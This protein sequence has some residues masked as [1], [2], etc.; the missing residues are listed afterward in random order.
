M[1]INKRDRLII[2]HSRVLFQLMRSR[3]VMISG[4][5]SFLVISHFHFL[6]I[7][8]SDSR[9]KQIHYSYRDIMNPELE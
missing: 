4:L 2:Q 1:H 9:K 6:D 7:V 8:D 3:G 5:E